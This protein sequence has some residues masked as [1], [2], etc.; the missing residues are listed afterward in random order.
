MVVLMS[1]STEIY[2]RGKPY[3][4]ALDIIGLIFD[5]GLYTI[6]LISLVVTLLKKDKKK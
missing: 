2:E 4:S 5:F 3:L 1:I 6:A